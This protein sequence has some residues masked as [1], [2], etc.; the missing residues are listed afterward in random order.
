M[1]RPCRVLDGTG[2][3]SIENR[4]SD[5]RAATREQ[6]LHAF[7]RD[8]PVLATPEEPATRAAI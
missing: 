3:A 1:A 7:L 2:P 5:L 6:A 4:I 8:V